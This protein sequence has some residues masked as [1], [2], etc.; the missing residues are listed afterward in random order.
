MKRGA[1]G[2]DLLNVRLPEG[3]KPENFKEGSPIELAVDVVVFESSVF[4][5]ATRDLKAE[6]RGERPAPPPAPMPA[7]PPAKSA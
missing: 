4:Y 1:K 7:A 6:A 2:Y 3:V 5:R